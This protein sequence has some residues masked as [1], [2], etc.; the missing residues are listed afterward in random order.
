MPI[1]FQQGARA[2][3]PYPTI[4]LKYMRRFHYLLHFTNAF[5]P[6]LSYLVQSSIPCHQTRRTQGLSVPSPTSFLTPL[7]YCSPILRHFA[8][9]PFYTIPYLLQLVAQ[10]YSLYLSTLFVPESIA[11]A[12]FYLGLCATVCSSHRLFLP[13]SFSSSCSLRSTSPQPV[14]RAMGCHAA[15]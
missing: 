5:S 10:R 14:H 12:L 4:C 11:C 7:Q 8:Q 1:L 6:R 13:S 2:V 9:T 3:N 15:W